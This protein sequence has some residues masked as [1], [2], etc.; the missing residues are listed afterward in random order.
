MKLRNA[1]A[2]VALGALLPLASMSVRADIRVV[3]DSGATVVLQSPAK[4]IVSLAPH[5]TELL[6]AAG[7]VIGS[8]ARRSSATIRRR[9]G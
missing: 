3:D 6:F 1:V 2:N 7:A 9:Q 4:R 5:V 8:S